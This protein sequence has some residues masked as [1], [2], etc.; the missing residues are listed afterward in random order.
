MMNDI[1]PAA[2]ARAREAEEALRARMQRM[3]PQFYQDIRY[4]AQ[5]Q[6]RLDT[7]GAVRPV[8]TALLP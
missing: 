1:P 3:H 2:E 4:V 7:E 8:C 6:S 5:S